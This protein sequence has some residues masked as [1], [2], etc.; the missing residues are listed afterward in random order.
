M[1]FFGTAYSEPALIAL[2]Y[3][4]EHATSVRR[5]PAFLPTLPTS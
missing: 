4:F 5:P 1:S 2:G 3:S